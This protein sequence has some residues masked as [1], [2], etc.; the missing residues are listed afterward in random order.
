M[1][2]VITTTKPAVYPPRLLIHTHTFAQGRHPAGSSKGGQF[3]SGKSGKSG[4]G[5][6]PEE[7]EAARVKLDALPVDHAF[8]ESYTSV[9]H[10]MPVASEDARVVVEGMKWGIAEDVGIEI[11]D[12][13]FTDLGDP[14]VK[15]IEVSSLRSE[16]IQNSVMKGRV[17]QYIKG[18]VA[19][20]PIQV[21]DVGGEL[22]VWNG[23][24]RSTAAIVKGDKTIS[25]IVVSP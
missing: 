10:P 19:A 2:T 24:H 11:E 15:N 22:I 16:G 25:A 8:S 12:V 7:I 6:S 18:E 5:I 1:I 21:I 23:H 20:D 4:S 17:V 13:G 9:N 14:V 3:A